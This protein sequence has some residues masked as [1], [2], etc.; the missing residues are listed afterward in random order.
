[1]TDPEFADR[2]YIEP[3]TLDIWKRSF[4]SSAN[5]ARRWALLLLP[6]SW[7]DRTA[8]NLAIELSDGGILE[9]YDVN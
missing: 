9:K 7:A 1:M 8:L 5:V 3:L 4:A 6:N 2:T